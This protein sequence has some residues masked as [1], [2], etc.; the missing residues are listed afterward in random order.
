MEEPPHKRKRSVSDDEGYEPSL[1]A[2]PHEM[3]SGPSHQQPQGNRFGDGWAKRPR[4]SVLPREA[5]LARTIC[6]EITKIGEFAQQLSIDIDNVSGSIAQE[7]DTDD[8]VRNSVLEFLLALIVEQPQKVFV[9][10]AL[11]QVSNYRNPKIGQYVFDFLHSQIQ[12]LFEEIRVPAENEAQSTECGAITKLK[13]ILRFVAVLS[14]MMVSDEP[15]IKTF[16]HIL[17]LAI[18]IQSQTEKRSGVAQILYFN[19]LTL[20]PYHLAVQ[21]D[22]E[23]F[24]Q[25]LETARK[26]KIVDLDDLANQSYQHFKSDNGPY[27]PKEI[28]SLILPALESV[29]KEL[30]FFMDMLQIVKSH[31]PENPEKH[32]FQHF[33]IPSV[34]QW[35]S[36]KLTGTVDSLWNYPRYA[37]E[38]FLPSATLFDTV[39]PVESYL[40]LLLR[41]IV[42]DNVQNMEFNRVTVSRQLLSLAVY[43][44]EK[45][46]AKP[47]SSIDKLTILNNLNS[48]VD[49]ISSLESNEDLDPN[50]KA[51]MIESATL[52]QQEFDQGYTSTWKME[53][54]VTEA[55]LGLMFHLPT[56]S[57][58]LI[59][60]QMLLSD[61]CGRDWANVRRSPN[62]ED[63][64][65][66]AKVLGTAFRFFY[67]NFKYLDLELCERFIQ[68]MT[69]QLSNFGFDWQWTEWIDDLN[70]LDKLYYHPTMYLFRNVIGR[71]IR[72]SSPQTIKPT[73]PVEFHRFL[74]LSLM[75]KRQVIN[76]DSK[77][78]GSKLA[79]SV[80]E[81]NFAA[82]ENIEGAAEDAGNAE[83]YHLV[84]Q[85][86][87]NNQ[88]HPYHELCHS[89]YTN[90]QE[91]ESLQQFNDLVVLLKQQI[92]Q[93]TANHPGDESYVVSNLD[94]YIVTLVI[95]STCIIGSRS[96]SV[97]EGGALE[98]CGA[99]LRKVLGL[100]AAEG[101]HED[102]ENDQFA[103][104][105]ESEVAE[106]QK[107]LI[108]GVLRLWNNEPR[109]GYL[110]LERIKR[111]GFIT[112][113]QLVDSF[114]ANNESLLLISQTY[115]SELFDRL[116]TSADSE[117]EAAE[118]LNRLYSNLV[119]HINLFIEKLGDDREE[120]ILGSVETEDSAD[121]DIELRWGL[122]G[123]FELLRSKMRLFSRAT[124]FQNVQQL[125][126]GGIRSEVARKYVADIADGIS[127]SVD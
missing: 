124:Q 103:L 125:I 69:A 44:N 108:D 50:V 63:K 71:E 73:L 65:T 32:I 64:V 87:F 126:E 29:D 36:F 9:I 8:F 107:W 70:K 110:I 49:L 11:V 21:K 106:R 109:I 15:V 101:E 57:S 66:F 81:T 42:Q 47:N 86:L 23:A 24:N 12:E 46:F 114:F 14:P 52:V 76:F 28:V 55:V 2:P 96:L 62:S 59:Y 119:E 112:G 41:D 26:F 74:R 82:E 25:L 67:S 68:W 115:A 91:G 85:Y 6:N 1:A 117:S 99:K 30:P 83:I 93:E 121:Q 72:L 19:I 10:G 38:C 53:Q 127:L 54:V 116:V 84:D 80:Y 100:P 90:I 43:F 56:A 31:E 37:L 27:K 48:G 98:L 17:D 58:P 3:P 92:E 120:M 113:T 20:I 89:I 111:K 39:P 95:Q 105:K 75:D 97:V 35:Q 5:E 7:L 104:L 34:E 18:D 118:V 79:E 51:S 40:S 22:Q 102:L 88:D 60:Y 94:C 77:L 45:L 78:F 122:R 4:R 33:N 13:L 123:C 61:T 16:Q